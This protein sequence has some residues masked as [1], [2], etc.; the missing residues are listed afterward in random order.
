MIRLGTRGSALALVNAYAAWRA[1]GR[2]RGWWFGAAL[3]E[4]LVSAMTYGYFVPELY[5][6]S[7]GDVGAAHVDRFAVRAE[8]HH[9]R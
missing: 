3:L 8:L 4:L 6:L 1:K 7:P 5:A 2:A 9:R